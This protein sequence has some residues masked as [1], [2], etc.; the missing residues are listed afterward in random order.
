MGSAITIVGKFLWNVAKDLFRPLCHQAVSYG[1]GLLAEHVQGR[2]RGHSENIIRNVL[3]VKS[4]IM[5]NIAEIFMSPQGR[6]RLDQ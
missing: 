1:T 3:P 6:R 5:A 4:A 2:S